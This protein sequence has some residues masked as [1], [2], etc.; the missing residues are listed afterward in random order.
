MDKYELLTRNMVEVVTEEEA[1]SVLERGKIKAYIGFEPSGLP[2]LGT[3]VFW[4]KKLNDLVELGIDLT[5]LLADWHA[6]VNDKLGGDLNIIRKSGDLL[7]KSMKAMGLHPSVKFVWAQDLVSDPEYWKT[8]LQVAKYSNL[9]RIVRA[10]PIMG[11]TEEDADKDFSKYIYPLM[12]VTDIFYMDLDLAL[13]GMDQRHAHMLA[14]DIAE[15]MGRKKVISIHG[16]LLGS[17]TGS[18]RMDSFKKMS[19]SDPNSAIFLSDSDDE[20]KRKIRNAYCP[21]KEIEGNPLVDIVKY[22]II[23]YYGKEFVIKRPKEKGGEIALSDYEEFE[24]LYKEGKVHPMDLK[25]ALADAISEILAPSRG[26]YQRERDIV[27][28]LTSGSSVPR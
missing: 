22:I 5:I 13:G 21:I 27:Q 7:E 16:P 26:L 25:E 17:L 4:P 23:P 14:R 28:L 11:R 20:V 2:H 1:R 19:K 6:M 24:S 3:S 9:K 18:G 15:K 12:Q 8:L 10:L